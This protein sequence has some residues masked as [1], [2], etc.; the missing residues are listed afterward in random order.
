MAEALAALRAYLQA[1][2]SGGQ[3]QGLGQ[4]H[5]AAGGWTEEAPWEA[6]PSSLGRGEDVSVDARQPWMGAREGGLGGERGGPHH[7]AG[8][9][10]R[11]AELDGEYVQPE[12][13]SPGSGAGQQ[14]TDRQQQQQQQQEQQD[15]G[16]GSGRQGGVGGGWFSSLLSPILRRGT[17]TA[18]LTAPP[19]SS[20]LPPSLHGPAS[21]AG[22]GSGAQA[23]RPPVGEGE[24]DA[25][26]WHVD[27][28]VKRLRMEGLGEGP[29]QR[30]GWQ[31]QQDHYHHQG[32]RAAP[33]ALMSVA[34]RAHMHDQLDS[35]PYSH[36][37]S[38]VG[39]EALLG[40]GGAEAGAARALF[41]SD[42]RCC[43]PGTLHRC[44][45]SCGW[46]GTALPHKGDRS[47]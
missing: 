20:H 5:G 11:G 6:P 33:V 34:P 7:G 41:G 24:G 25:E 4:R 18:T 12:L 21:P 8:E 23:A 28:P 43:L 14:Q 36:P 38:R 13:R 47:A 19:A 1:E 26:R 32:R 3:G 44:G 27:R 39:D 35:Q 42:N 45:R 30:Q 46:L 37:P 2:T 40:L 9:V 10:D 22:G 17:S 29:W 16:G 15:N 31:Q